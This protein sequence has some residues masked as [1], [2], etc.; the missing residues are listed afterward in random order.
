LAKPTYSIFV[1]LIIS[2][3]LLLLLPVANASYTVKNLNVTI[4]LNP[5]TSAQVVESLQV[6]ISNVSVSQYSTN[7]AALNLSLS[8]WQSLIGP[9]LVQHVISPNSSVYNFKFLPG[10][11]SKQNGQNVANIILVYYVKNITSVNETAPRVFQYKFNPRFFNFEHGA[12]GEVLT[13]NTTLTMIIPQSG[14]ITTAYPIPDLPPYV[15]TT[16][17]KNTTKVSWLYGE[18]LSKFTLIYWVPQSIPAEVEGFFTA[19]YR[20]L[21][22]FTYIIIAVAV[23]LFILYVYHRASR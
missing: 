6:D 7:R 19:I 22:L 15:F 1:A 20:T 16:N 21:G 9:L 12:S 14:T 17:Y 10:P 3:G 11:V 8:N 23:I 5:N 2:I 4:T 13:P 18:P